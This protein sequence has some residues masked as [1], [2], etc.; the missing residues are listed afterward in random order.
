MAA[1]YA[2]VVMAQRTSSSVGKKIITQQD[3]RLVLDMMAMDIRNAS[4]NRW[5]KKSEGIWRG[6]N[7][8]L[9]P[10]DN[11]LYGIQDADQNNILVEMDLNED[12]IIGPP[13][14]NEAIYYK[15]NGVNR[16]TRQSR[17]R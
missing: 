10:V 13:G 5:H 11:G 3:A 9:S 2:A 17:F 15:Y 16:I 1:V 6:T 4:Y 8:D 14:N 7:G 12:S